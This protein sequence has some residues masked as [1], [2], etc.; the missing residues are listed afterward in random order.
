MAA[1]TIWT[2]AKFPENTMHRL[3]EGVRPHRLVQSAGATA[4]NLAG[5][6]VDPLLDQADIAFGQPDP[7]QITGQ[8]RLRWVQLTTAGYTRYDT[9]AFR[10]AVKKN[11][12]AT[13]GNA[14][15]VYA[16]P[17]AQHVLA[18]MLAFSRRLPECWANQHGKKDW[19]Y[20]PLRADSQLLNGQTVLLVGYGSIGKRLAELL[21][22]FHM[23][24]I[25]FRRNPKGDEN[26]VRMLPIAQLDEWLAKADHVVNMLPSSRETDEFFNADRMP[27]IRRG[28]FYYN[29]GRGTT[30]DELALQVELQTGGL[31]AAY[32]DAFCEEPLAPHHALWT[33]PRCFIT[34]HTAGGHANEFDRHVDLFLK[35]LKQFE[36]GGALIDRIM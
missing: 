33:T 19:P 8:P 7:D 17:C 30:N 11:G 31:S 34:P 1:M 24:V 9:P 26:G 35:N 25:G 15:S 10:A 22:P 36:S 32:V 3:T 14:S 18:M 5:A 4:N 12:T 6:G 2:N 23:Q 13:I 28:A 27:K 21:A 20:L 16:D 29:I